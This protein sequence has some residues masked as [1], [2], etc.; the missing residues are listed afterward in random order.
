MHPLNTGSLNEKISIEEAHRQVDD[1]IAKYQDTISALKSHRNRYA[2]ISRLPSEITSRIFLFVKLQDPYLGRAYTVNWIKVT[3]VTR[4]WRNIAVN[5]PSLWVD[6]PVANLPWVEEMLRRSKDAS[7]VINYNF[8]SNRILPGLALALKHTARARGLSFRKV[9]S[10]LWVDLQNVYRSLLHGWN[11]L[12]WMATLLSG[13]HSPEPISITG[14]IL[15]ETGRL[16]Y[17]ELA[18]CGVNWKSHSHILHSLTHLKIHNLSYPSRPDG[19]QFVDILKGM[20]NLESLDLKD[21]L[22]VQTSEQAPWPTDRIHFTSLQTLNIHSTNNELR[23]FFSCVTFPP[24]ATVNVVCSATD[25]VTS[26]LNSATDFSDV[27][28]NIGR[29]FSNCSSAPIFQSFVLREP[30]QGSGVQFELYTDVLDDLALSRPEFVPGL[31]LAFFLKAGISTELTVDKLLLDVF[32]GALHLQ[33]VKRLYLA[34]LACNIDSGTIAIT[35]GKLPSV[36]SVMVAAGASKPF[37]DALKLRSDDA[38]MGPTTSGSMSKLY[39]PCLSSICLRETRFDDSDDLT[40]DSLQDTL[41]QRHE[42]GAEIK[43][44]ILRNCF[45]LETD[46]VGSLEEIVDNVDWD[47]LEIFTEDEDEYEYDCYCMECRLNRCW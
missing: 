10:N 33:H 11:A 16:R 31:K 7:L 39:F 15:S 29:S 28:S 8:S 37:L 12:L 2:L 35:V 36:R 46:G 26:S 5:S 4:H 18:N 20:P 9:T 21:V 22:P 45:R 41:I 6:L 34:N 3:H 19:K 30:T 13:V 14:R 40:V 47:G 43:K 38:A 44:L 23:P 17:L 1:T 25:A 27:I 32:D 24:T 42:C